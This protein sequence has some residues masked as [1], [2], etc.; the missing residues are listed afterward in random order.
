MAIFGSNSLFTITS[1]TTVYTPSN[2][3]F[4]GV[5]NSTEKQYLLYSEEQKANIYKKGNRIVWNYKLFDYSVADIAKFEDVFDKKDTVV[6]FKSHN[7]NATTY[8]CYFDFFV[9]DIVEPYYIE[10]VLTNIELEVL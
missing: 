3:R 1:L 10:I 6:T 2:K 9:Y 7:D 5:K 8:Q 4:E